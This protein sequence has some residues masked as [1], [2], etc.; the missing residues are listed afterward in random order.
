MF[1]CAA[2]PM[3]AFY[4]RW[5]I[6]TTKKLTLEGYSKLY[7]R[8]SL[9]LTSCTCTPFCGVGGSEGWHLQ[10]EN[11]QY[12]FPKSLKYP[13]FPPSCLPPFFPYSLSLFLPGS[14]PSTLRTNVVPDTVLCV[15]KLGEG[16][17]GWSVLH[18]PFPGLLMSLPASSLPHPTYSYSQFQMNLPK[19]QLLAHCFPC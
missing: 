3:L 6:I 11:M 12:K 10:V 13:S 5:Y 16:S 17:H 15:R 7:N 19:A 8:S 2:F 18:G 4:I 1:P 14:H 9:D